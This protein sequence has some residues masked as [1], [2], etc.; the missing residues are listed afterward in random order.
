MF[1]HPSNDS[2]HPNLDQVDKSIV[3][4]LHKDGRLT[5]YSLAKKMDLST[6]TVARRISSLCKRNVIEIVA[7]PN[8]SFFGNL[9]G[10][11]LLLSVNHDE[12]EN[13]CQ[14]LIKSENVHLLIKL[15][16]GFDLLVG[17]HCD[18]PEILF[19][20]IS[21]HISNLKGID[22]IDILVRA[23]IRKRTY[24]RT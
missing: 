22:R 12:Q 20:H 3:E 19:Q 2:E 21:Q 15:S 7:V 17:V 18:T 9:S 5:Y 23:Q 16:N 1:S 8:P 11:F 14:N 13:I 24:I 10:V 4:M 6:P